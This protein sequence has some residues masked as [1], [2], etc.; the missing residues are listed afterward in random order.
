MNLRSVRNRLRSMLRAGLL[1][2]CLGLAAATV[3][4][5]SVNVRGRVTYPNGT[6][7]PGAKVEILSEASSPGWWVTW[8]AYNYTDNNGNYTLP[9]YSFGVPGVHAYYRVR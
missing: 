4:A 6:P 3:E 7:F 5:A 2:V 1:V 9:A 8:V